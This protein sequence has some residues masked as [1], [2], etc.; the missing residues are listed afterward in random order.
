MQLLRSVAKMKLQ[1]Q[2]PWQAESAKKMNI[3]QSLK[4]TCS[5]AFREA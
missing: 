3:S 5:Q 2:L 4:L 1:G